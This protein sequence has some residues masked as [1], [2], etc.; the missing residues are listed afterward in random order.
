M[1]KGIA[2]SRVVSIDSLKLWDRNPRSIKTERFT[3]LK[4]RLKRQGQI[5]PLLV[6]KDGKTVIGG[7]MRLRAMR[8][9]GIEEVWVSQTEASTDKEIFDLAL[10]DNEEF[11]YYEQ[12]Q[13]AELAI[14]LGLSPLELKS[15]ALSL[16]EPTT[17]DLVLDK[18]GPEVEE[19]EAPAVDEQNPP[20]SQLGEI[21]LLGAHRVMCGDSTDSDAV[22]ELMDG[23]KA[24]MV[25][26][27]P[28]YGIGISSNPVRQKH[29]KSNWDDNPIDKVQ[30]DHIFSWCNNAIIWGGN[31][32]DLPPSQGFLIWDKKQPEDFSLAMCEMAWS[33]V[34]MPAKIY[35][36]SV[37][38]YS[39]EHP[40]QKP[41]GLMM[42]CLKICKAGENILDFYGGSGSTLIA[43]EQTNRTCYM[44]ELDPKYCDVIRKRYAKHIGEEEAWQEATPAVKSLANV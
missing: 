26:T 11:G 13:V 17:L 37:T 39:K 42:W 3:E 21:Y 12:E 22:A 29:E 14:E 24:D 8:E 1:D 16:G 33:S 38:S 10:T 34:Q 4:E 43:C 25:L 40:T 2:E 30:V 20:V 5:K 35:S 15:Y 32:F 18:F 6:A 7:N 28:P 19:D 36:E 31:Y 41:V 27:D 44:M 9:L 23:A